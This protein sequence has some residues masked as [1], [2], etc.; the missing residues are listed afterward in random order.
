MKNSL[1]WSLRPCVW[2][3]VCVAP[4]FPTPAGA[5]DDAAPAVG[6]AVRDIT[7][8]PPIRLAGYASSEGVK[9]RLGTR[10]LRQDQVE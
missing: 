6:I 9:A 5:A 2:L 7:P 10:V 3:A 4:F 1:A 8:E